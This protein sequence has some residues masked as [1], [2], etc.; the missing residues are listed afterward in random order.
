MKQKYE[1]LTPYYKKLP[2]RLTDKKVNPTC[3]EF[4]RIISYGDGEKYYR[5][6]ELHSNIIA[7]LL[8]PLETHNFNKKFFN[9]FCKNIDEN[10]STRNQLKIS[11]EVTET[12]GEKEREADI[13]IITDNHLIVIEN[14]WNSLEGKNQFIDTCEIFKHKADEKNLDF[15]YMIL[16]KEPK[17]IKIPT[18]FNDSSYCIGYDKIFYS[19]KLAEKANKIAGHPSAKKL[20]Q[21]YLELISAKTLGGNMD[22]DKDMKDFYIAHLDKMPL[23]GELGEKF[24]KAIDRI[25]KY[26]ANANELKWIF[27]KQGKK[28]YKEEWGNGRRFN[29]FICYINNSNKALE[30]K[31]HLTKTFLKNQKL[32]ASIKNIIKTLPNSVT[33]DIEPD[34]FKIEI[35]S[36]EDMMS[37]GIKEKLNAKIKILKQAGEIISKCIKENAS[38]KP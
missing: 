6:E 7:W 15:I 33:E 29:R 30:F 5:K 11:R 3:W 20:I 19:I 32:K 10:I 1:I 14:K 18:D 22:F 36:Q 38:K 21:E 12:M 26:I 37:T 35:L 2:K 24:N 16:A 34:I 28:L 4:F 9:N 27:K 23:I 13:E 25:C 17:N 31:F 8:D